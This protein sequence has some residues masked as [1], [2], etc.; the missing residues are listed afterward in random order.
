MKVFLRMLL[1]LVALAGIGGTVYFY[2]NYNK[3]S[4]EKEM[5]IQENAQLQ[6]NIDAIGP[7]TVAYTVIDSMLS[8]NV[9]TV[10]D[11]QEITIPVSAVTDQTIVDISAVVGE[12][13]KVDVHPGTVLTSDLVMSNEFDETA[14]QQDMAFDFL[15]LGIRVGDYV[16]IK[17][18]LPY[19]ETLIVIPHKRVEN[20]VVDSH[21]INVYLTPAQ[22]L[23]WQSAMKDKALFAEY[24]LALYCTKYVEP[25]VQDDTFANYPI[26][27]EM[28]TVAM[29]DN[30]VT[31][32]T[33][34]INHDLRV[35]IDTLIAVISEDEENQDGGKLSSGVG[36]ESSGINAAVGSYVDSK[37]SSSISDAEGEDG[38]Y[39]DLDGSGD[40]S[41]SLQG[42]DE[43]VSNYDYE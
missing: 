35:G 11:F 12:L 24:G 43:T 1:V 28:E 32:K 17:M 9:I 42:L 14:Y 16:D 13:Y 7:V 8:G 40:V 38:D 18:T 30:N 2:V 33:E 27:Q 25:G 34:C 29:I 15:P 5:Y 37:N 31:D 3:V 4:K 10:D 41:D 26:R 39:I 36:A 23:L 19:G 6:S 20:V 22:Q 21:V